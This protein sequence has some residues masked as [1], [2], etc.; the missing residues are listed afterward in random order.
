[1]STYSNQLQPA[2]QN[3]LQHVQFFH[4]RSS[5]TTTHI[6]ADVRR[7]TLNVS[8]MTI[9]GGRTKQ[10]D[11][12]CRITGFTSDFLFHSCG[13]Y[14]VLSRSPSIFHRF[15]NVQSSN[16]RHCRFC[17]SIHF[18]YTICKLLNG[19]L[20]DPQSSF[21]RQVFDVNYTGVSF[22]KLL[23]KTGK[24]NSWS[25]LLNSLLFFQKGN[26]TTQNKSF[27]KLPFFANISLYL[28][29]GTRRATVTMEH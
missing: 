7:I 19:T 17:A 26:W 24:I 20:Y 4:P 10:L 9:L 22:C 18:Q 2:L 3:L 5:C 28:E 25:A 14:S 15:C 21:Q 27:V 13:T 8:C 23:I 16:L 6:S 29:N 1:M 11:I 12:L